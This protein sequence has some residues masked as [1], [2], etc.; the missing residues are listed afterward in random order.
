[1]S[2]DQ[3]ENVQF[4]GLQP[5]IFQEAMIEVMAVGTEVHGIV[6]MSHR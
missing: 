2:L 6:V 4:V 5:V 1:M 3:V